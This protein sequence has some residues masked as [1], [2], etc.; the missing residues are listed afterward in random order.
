MMP[1]LLFSGNASGDSRKFVQSRRA[2]DFDRGR[3]GTQYQPRWPYAATC[4]RTS[5]V[6]ELNKQTIPRWHHRLDGFRRAQPP[7]Y[8]NRE[9]KTYDRGRMQRRRELRWVQRDSTK[10]SRRRSERRRVVRVLVGSIL[11]PET[12][13]G[14]VASRRIRAL[15][16][17]LHIDASFVLNQV[18]PCAMT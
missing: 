13:R 11:P 10:P 4:D 14:R 7:A 6:P 2:G 5:I 17:P 1:I 8:R 16:R 9:P 12:F 15:T 18:Q 3:S